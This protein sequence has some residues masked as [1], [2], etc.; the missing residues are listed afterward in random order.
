M[1]MSVAADE[2]DDSL[3][4]ISFKNQ[5]IAPVYLNAPPFKGMQCGVYSYLSINNH[6]FN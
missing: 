6:K 2:R 1:L 4:N 5:F 3:S